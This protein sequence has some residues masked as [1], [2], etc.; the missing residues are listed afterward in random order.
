MGILSK[1]YKGIKA[2]INE[3]NKPESFTKG[4]DFEKYVREIVFPKDKYDL[5][6]KTHSYQ[7]NKG[8]YIERTLYPDFLFRCK[9]TKKEFYVEAK[10][11][12]NLFKNK[13]QWS[14][15]KQLKRYK[16]INKTKT[17]F[18]CLGFKGTPKS[19]EQIFIIPI[20]KIKFKG[21]YESSIKNYGFYIDKPVFPSYLWSL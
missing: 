21:L 13:I 12:A 19:P 6:Q 7:D 2:G 9:K 3:I 11:R 16:D 17:V 15:D 4:E 8:D 20:S 5:I 1:I 10:F 14:N 18:L